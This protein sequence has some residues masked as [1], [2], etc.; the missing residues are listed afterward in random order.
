MASG[1]DV[2]NRLCNYFSQEGEYL[3]DIVLQKQ[4]ACI[5]PYTC[6]NTYSGSLLRMNVHACTHADRHSTRAHTRKNTALLARQHGHLGAALYQHPFCLPVLRAVAVLPNLLRACCCCVS[7]IFNLPWTR[8]YDLSHLHLF[9]DV[10]VSTRCLLQA[11]TFLRQST[12]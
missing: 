1:S 5:R 11:I 2:S 8:H 4:G 3:S 6:Q 12:S 7:P 10:P 9:T